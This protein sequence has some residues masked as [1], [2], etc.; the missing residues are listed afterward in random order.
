MGW[1]IHEGDVAQDFPT[2][3][4]LKT[5]RIVCRP[6]VGIQMMPIDFGNL[7][8]PRFFRTFGDTGR[9]TRFGEQ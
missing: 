4:M 5:N 1:G 6:A 2:D 7:A 8:K 3:G 9:L